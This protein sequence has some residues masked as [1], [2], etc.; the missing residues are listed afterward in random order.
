MESPI[1]SGGAMTT[2]HSASKFSNLCLPI[3]QI[4]DNF[5]NT[6]TQIAFQAFPMFDAK[7]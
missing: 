1:F 6:N 3:N 2:S 7:T 5:Q 4:R